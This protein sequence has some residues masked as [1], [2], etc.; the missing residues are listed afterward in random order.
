MD[1]AGMSFLDRAL[2]GDVNGTSVFKLIPL[3][4]SRRR[5]S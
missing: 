1:R 2:T 3:I 5:L 4:R